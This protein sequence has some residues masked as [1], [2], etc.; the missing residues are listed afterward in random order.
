MTLQPIARNLEELCDAFMYK[1][2]T[3]ARTSS[4]T[5]ILGEIGMGYPNQTPFGYLGVVTS[6]ILWQTAAGRGTGEL[7]AGLDDWLIPYRIILCHQPH[8]Y[9]QPIAAT[10]SVGNAFVGNA[11]YL[12]QPGYRDWI[13]YSAAIEGCLRA[14]ITLSG[15]AATTQIMEATPILQEVE[16]TLYHAV[17]IVV[18]V[19]QRRVRGA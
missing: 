4:I 6:Q 16:G 5:W 17:R 12:E 13:N 18:N 3:D 11:P 10:P 9:I 2:A 14:D 7:A 15:F 19:Q 1:L 8:Q